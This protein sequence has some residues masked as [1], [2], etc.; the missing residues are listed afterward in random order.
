VSDDVDP[1]FLA[2]DGANIYA[3]YCDLR[4]IP[5]AGGDPVVLASYGGA[6]KIRGLAVDANNIYFCLYFGDVRSVPIDASGVPSTQPVCQADNLRNA[7]TLIAQTTLDAAGQGDACGGLSIDASNVY[8]SDSYGLY[9]VP[10]TGGAVTTLTTL[11]SPTTAF[12]NV[13]TSLYVGSWDFGQVWKI[14][15]SGGTLDPIATG[16]LGLFA[17]AA[18][19]SYL[20]WSAAGVLTRYPLSGGTPTPIATSSGRGVAVDSGGVYFCDAQQ[21]KRFDKSDGHLDVVTSDPCGN[22]IALDDAF[23]YFRYCP[24]GNCGSLRKVVKP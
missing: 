16:Q 14:S 15:S 8:F 1:E 10:K 22:T 2:V 11:P 18:D 13:G 21:L 19:P 6:E 23:V 9:K 12:L 20:Y 7:G 3:A 24:N 4:R 5:L 17:F